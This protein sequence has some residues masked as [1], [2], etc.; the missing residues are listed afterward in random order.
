MLRGHIKLIVYCNQTRRHAPPGY[1]DLDSIIKENKIN[2]YSLWYVMHPT[3]CCFKS[4]K[5]TLKVRAKI[6]NSSIKDFVLLRDLEGFIVNRI[7]RDPVLLIFI[8]L[9]TWIWI[10]IL[11]H[12]IA[13][14]NVLSDLW[15]C[16]SY[17][18]F[19]S[20]QAWEVEHGRRWVIGS[21]TFWKLQ[22]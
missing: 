8:S 18:G 17:G 6:R 14:C 19:L 20:R 7:V 16:R 22:L 4:I 21:S 9:V 11:C 2:L 10:L 13:I 3:P 5:R 15:L 1:H 12:H